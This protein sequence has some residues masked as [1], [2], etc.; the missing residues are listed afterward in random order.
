VTD[1]AE[2]HNAE[3]EPICRK[4]IELRYRLLP[5]NYTL[6]RESCDTGLPPMRALWL[7]YPNDPEAV[8]LGDEYL[9]G[10]DILVAPVVEKGANSRR[11]YLPAGTWYDWWTNERLTGGRWINCPVDLTTLPLYVR[12]GAII[13]LDPI[14]QFTS[15]KVSQ[16]TTLQVYPGADGSFTLYEDDG[17]SLDYQRDLATWTHLKWNDRDRTLSVEPDRRSKAKPSG[18]RTFEVLLMPDGVRKTAEYS[19][20]RMQVNFQK[21][22]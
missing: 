21:Q 13:P 7:H 1:R 18:S 9:W 8:K 22:L 17:S 11:L 19:G 20:R 12:A 4:Y 10:R 14:R 16:P 5:Y 6:M 15:E 3:V 2:L